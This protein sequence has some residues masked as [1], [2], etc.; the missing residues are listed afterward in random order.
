MHLSYRLMLSLLCAVAA[1]SMAFAVYQVQAERHALNDEVQRQAIVLAESQANSVER[2]LETDSYGDLQTLVDQFRHHQQLAGMAV[3][4]NTGRALAITSS[5]A[6]HV[7]PTPAAVATAIRTG[8]DRGENYDSGGQRLRIFASPLRQYGHTTGAIAVFYNAAFTAAPVWRHALSGMA[9]TLLIVGFTL[10]IVHWT[11]SKPLSRM[12]VWLRDLRTGGVSAEGRP[13]KETIFQSLTG[14]LTQLATSLHA[15]R[16]AAEEE[17]RLRAAS[18]SRWTAER[19]RIAVRAKLDGSRLFAVSNREPYEHKHQGGSIAW[20]IPPSGL[21]TALEPVL[22]ASDGT[23]IAQGTGDADRET[24]D[25]HGRLRVPPDHP[26]YGLR[27]V[28]LTKEEE[29]GFYFGFANEGLWPLCHIAHTRPIF[30]SGDWHQYQAVNRKFTAVLLDEMHGEVQPVVLAQDYHF[31]LLP[32]MVKEK[33]PDARIA[34]FW[35]IPWPNPEAFG[36][37]PWQREL[38]DGMLGADL[39]GFHIQAHCN[40][41]LETVDQALESRIDWEHFAVNRHDHLTIVRPFPISVAT[42]GDSLTPHDPSP[43]IQALLHREMGARPAFLGLGV[44]RIDYTKGIPERLRGIER[45]FE[46]HPEFRE[47]FTFIQIGAPSRTHIK[48]Y[49]DLMTEVEAEVERINRNF[50]TSSWKPIVFV[51]RHHSHAEV[52]AYYRE[53]DVCMVTSLHDGMNLV[54]KEFLA[55]RPDEQGMLILSRFTGASHELSDAL[56][57]NPYDTDE[58]AE[59]IYTALTMPAEEQRSR[60]H[61]MRTVI[62][63]NNVYRWAG[64]LIGELAGIRL[65]SAGSRPHSNGREPDIHREEHSSRVGAPASAVRA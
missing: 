12:A 19:L 15:A 25:Q 57:V 44:D 33:R 41:F 13:P 4:D 58:L 32:R 14:E 39:I 61:R 3:Y 9:Q 31:A 46:L 62:K 30:R 54:A 11:V 42:N 16:A 20:S 22:R 10:L 28:W 24:A 63:E 59:A 49:Q 34:I 27:R 29:E 48:R 50:R 53:A 26:Q 21:V 38:L 8:R 40:N 47:K 52:E 18:L 23:W 64:N 6:S 51:A 60:M 37:C 17:A 65:E 5:L 7:Q 45:L 1:V 43:E 56:V 2:L 55:A 36:I 35:H